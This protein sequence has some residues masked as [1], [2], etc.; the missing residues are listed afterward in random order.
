MLMN[1]WKLR[2]CLLIFFLKL[3]RDK[4]GHRFVQAKLLCKLLVD[5]VMLLEIM[6]PE[7]WKVM[8]AACSTPIKARCLI[9]LLHLAKS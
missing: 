9:K 2:S 4:L 5:T 1:L 6:L 3:L 8:L 7:S